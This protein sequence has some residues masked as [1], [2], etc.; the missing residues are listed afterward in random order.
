MTA[1][2]N[3]KVFSEAFRE[4]LAA[5]T[6]DVGGILA[7][8][9]FYLLVIS[10]LD[11][12]Q[13]PWIIAVYPTILSAKGTFGGLLSGRLS[14]ALHVGTIYP[15][16][17]NNT[18]AFYKLFDAVIFINF[19]TCI[20]MGLISLVFGSLFWGISSPNFSEILSV[21][22]ATM[23]LGL[24]IS[25]LTMLVTFTSF[26]K[27]LD[28]D[29]TVYPIMS[30]VADITMTVCYAIILHI[31]FFTD[32]F[33]EYAVAAV[34]IA[35]AILALY[36]LMRNRHEEDFVKTVK[37]FSFTLIVVA[38][39]VNITGTFLYIISDVILTGRSEIYT[40]Y[41]ALMDLVGDVGSI[42]G[43]TATT[44]LTLGLLKPSLSS[45]K[46]HLNNV[47]GAWT[48]SL[49]MFTI[50]STLSLSINNALS[51]FLMFTAT[52]L[53]ANVIAVSLITLISYATAILT[54]HRGLDLDTFIIPIESSLADTVTSAALLVAIVICGYSL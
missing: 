13:A 4:S 5:Y 39:I 38:F 35:F 14:A 15:R 37:E 9:I 30:T 11:S 51:Q 40:V 41:P 26:K 6:F 21:L 25:M 47:F 36:I 24:T 52:I 27:G 18:K 8:F 54:F 2:M 23:A 34:A 17:L 44:K 42:I 49:V 53:T 50:L 32:F 19:E 7:G 43:S 20:A 1:K 31:F 29:I 12:F 3:S 45:I 16:F 10:K 48:A 33:G 22:M 46:G 28:T